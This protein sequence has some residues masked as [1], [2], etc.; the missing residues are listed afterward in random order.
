MST[1][2]SI[3]SSTAIQSSSTTTTPPSSS[4]SV[5]P[6]MS[7]PDATTTDATITVTSNADNTTNTTTAVSAAQSTA[8]NQ[9]DIAVHSTI[10]LSHAAS[11]GLSDA[12]STMFVGNTAVGTS[13]VDIAFVVGI[14][15]GAIVFACLAMIAGALLHRHCVKS[16]NSNSD[17][18]VGRGSVPEN[19]YGP[20]VAVPNDNQYALSSID[21]APRANTYD[22]IRVDEL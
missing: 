16:E 15:V 18:Q 11:V 14:V 10:S 12:D 21:I 7:Q 2:T 13:S 6:S 17:N 22:S 4:P 19:I 1:A 3:V 5:Q 20:I 9:T 8:A